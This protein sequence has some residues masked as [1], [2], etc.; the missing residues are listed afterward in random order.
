MKRPKRTATHQSSNGCP[1][2][3]DRFD[4]ASL[5]IQ[6]AIHAAQ[7]RI[8]IS[9]P[10]FVPDEGV[11]GMLKLAALGGIDVRILIP[12]ASDSRLVDH[13]AYA[14]AGPLLDAGVRIYR[15]QD[16]FLHGK[17]L[18]VDDSGAGIGTVN[19]DNRSF[20]LNFE[21]TAIAVDDDFASEVE[22]MFLADFERSRLMTR[23]DVDDRSLWS[24]IASRAAYLLAPLL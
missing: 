2:T 5:M 9:S 11:Q 16:G 21:I 20:R 3:L 6:Q 23:E 22:T 7:R 17:A 19:L 18:L 12:E 24:R 1:S 14:F 8:W 13:A 4:T 15:Y 10:Y